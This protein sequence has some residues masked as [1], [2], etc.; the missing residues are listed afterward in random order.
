[1]GFVSQVFSGLRLRLLVLVVLVCAPLVVLILHTA[2]EDRRRAEAGWQQRAQK[3]L[4]VT[5][6]EEQEVLASTAPT[7]ARPF[8]IGLG[9]LAQSPALQE[10]SGRIVCHLSSL[11]ESWGPRH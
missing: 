4:Q 1:M 6:R 3:L 8:G 2:W 10:I 5:D 9:P 7:S 11:C